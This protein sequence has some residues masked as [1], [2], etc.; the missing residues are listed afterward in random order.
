M[1]DIIEITI[2]AALTLATIIALTRLQ[3]LSSFSKMS[4]FDF[5]VT[6][7]IGLVLAG[8]VITLDTELEVYVAALASLFA[9]Q[10]IV[11]QS[12]RIIWQKPA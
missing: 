6:V 1:S 12:M 11:A 5:A 4:G 3:G 8:A 10:W 9:V 2:R 7:S